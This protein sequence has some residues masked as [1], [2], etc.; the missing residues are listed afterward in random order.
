MR[1]PISRLLA[2]FLLSLSLVALVSCGESGGADDDDEDH[3]DDAVSDDDSV[4]DDDAAPDAI[5]S[6]TP[7][8]AQ[9]LLNESHQGWKIPACFSCHETAHNGGFT[10]PQCASCHGFNGAPQR[11]SGHAFRDCSSCHSDIH[12]GLGFASPDDCTLCHKYVSSE[13]CPATDTTD[14]VVI[15]AG[16]GGLAAAAAL[17]KAGKKVVLIEKHHRVGGYMT[18][19][20]RGEYTFE[21][22]LHAMDGLDEPNGLNVATFKRLGLWDKV[23]RVRLDPM[24]RAIYPDLTLDVPADPEAYRDRLIDLYPSEADGITR[25]FEDLAGM[26]TVLSTIMRIVQDGF[27]WP[28]ALTL[29]DNAKYLLSFIKLLTQTV[30]EFV[31][32]YLH[33]PK[34]IAVWTIMANGGG[35]A[36]DELSALF[37]VIMWSS[38]HFNG[39]YNFEGGSHA[40]AQALEDS[41]RGNGG[42]IRLGTLATKIVI[43]DGRAVM[44]KTKDDVCYKMD[45]VV[46]NSNAPNTFLNLIGAEYLDQEQIDQLH[47]LPIGLSAVDVFLGVDHDYRDIFGSIHQIQ[48]LESYDPNEN[49]RFVREGIPEKAPMTINNYSVIAPGLAPVGK[50]SLLIGTQLPYD[51]QNRWHLDS[52]GFADYET[53]KREVAEIL[54]TRAEKVL[55]GLRDHIEVLEIGTPITMANYTL[56]PGGTIFGWDNSPGAMIAR[57]TL[58]PPIP[59]VFLAG[60]WGFPGGGQSLVLSSGLSAADA[61]LAADE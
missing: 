42:T 54:L 7:G 60:A 37:F 16:G 6:A 46:S 30:S 40:I 34:L 50:N 45:Y 48:V 55:P 11:V 12:T 27:S 43:E 49:F 51:W 36:P 20:R 29:L 52:G 9:A 21:V 57:L 1:T 44:V 25:L 3:D 47:T 59:N 32:Q 23:T 41:I 53:F 17:T 33:D 26:N 10:T 5:S 8:R 61:I 38:Y 56:N 31:G 2:L 18:N 19:V 22:S 24:Y 4:T 14:V 39:F 58:K 28:D 13:A 15:G 35:G